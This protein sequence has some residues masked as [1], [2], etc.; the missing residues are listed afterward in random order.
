MSSFDIVLSSYLDKVCLFCDL[1]HLTS[2][3]LLKHSDHQKKIKMGSKKHKKESKKKKHRSRSRSPL[4]GEE[5]ERKRHKKHKDRKKD[6]SPD[7]KF[8][9][10]PY[11]TTI[12]GG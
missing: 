4:D 2:L 11:L 3:K 12:A 6:R 7:G 8:H 1:K 10:P 9:P 5:R